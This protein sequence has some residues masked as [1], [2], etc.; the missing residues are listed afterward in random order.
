MAKLRL[1]Y[2]NVEHG[3]RNTAPGYSAYSGDGGGYDYR[4]VVGMFHDG[5]WP[6]VFVLGEGDRYELNGMEGA[7]E[8]AAALREAKG[9]AYV[10]LPCSLPREGGMFA[11]VIYVNPQKV[12]IRR[13]YHHRLPDFA[14]RNR[15]LFVFTL[16]GR[17]DPFRVIGWHGDIHSSDARLWDAREWDRFA[18]PEIPCAI[19][20]DWNSVPGGPN[21]EPTDL[22]TP[23]VHDPRQLAW[24]I[25]FTHGPAQAGPHKY[26]SSALDFLCG[27]WDDE[28]QERVGGVG[29]HYVAELAGDFTPTQ[30]ERPNGRQPV[31][32]DGMCINAPLV[33]AYVPGSY[34]VH[35]FRDPEKPESDHKRVSVTIDI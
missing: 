29:F 22:N 23:G 11:P 3:G 34:R 4:K 1:S 15:N 5:D 17:E 14:S 25:K 24:R 35:E 13:F 10:P 7:Y 12:V 26:D 2:V 9:P 32:L 18:R 6:D 28:R 27:W 8:A 16:P 19:L 20:G 33:D 21:F 30:I 31:A